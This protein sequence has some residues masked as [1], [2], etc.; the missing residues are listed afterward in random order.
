M[1]YILD[2]LKKADQKRHLGA[3]I[4]TLS[5]VHR[6]P[7][8]AASGRRIW[9]WIAGA[10][11]LANA[12]A[13][14]WLLRPTPTVPTGSAARSTE[15]P[16][17]SA[18]PAAP[19]QPATARRE[20]PAAPVT[21]PSTPTDKPAA[22]SPAPAAAEPRLAR[23]KPAAPAAPATMPP[24]AE[25]KKPRPADGA[26]GSPI[27]AAKRPATAGAPPTTPGAA[28]PEKVAS[29]P[30][31][32]G[33]QAI[34]RGPA[35]PLEP[36]AGPSPTPQS[37][38]AAAQDIAKMK[39][40]MLV[41]SEVPSERLVFIDDHKYVEGSSIDGRHVVESITSEGAVLSYQGKRFLLRR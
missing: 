11:I 37:A 1:S 3:Q 36:G 40:Q 21:P 8:P 22:V 27:A 15:T 18:P 29:A 26:G 31:K 13:L 14:A 12:A 19:A 35:K 2:A 16:A 20:E 28:P 25:L 32:S 34:A 30:E 7:T 41:Y 24:R 39:L 10:L 5:T 4:P 6:R 23:A 38:Q 33:A 17:A 9:P